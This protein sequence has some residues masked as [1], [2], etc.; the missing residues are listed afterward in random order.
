MKRIGSI[1]AIVMLG[2]AIVGFVTLYIL[3]DRHKA[4]ITVIGAEILEFE[5]SDSP[6]PGPDKGPWEV[7]LRRIDTKEIMNIKFNEQFRLSSGEGLPMFCK[8]LGVIYLDRTEIGEGSVYR[9][10]YTGVGEVKDL[11]H[12]ELI[13]SRKELVRKIASSDEMPDIS[14]YHFDYSFS[15][16]NYK[17]E[18]F[19]RFSTEGA[20]IKYTAYYDTTSGEDVRK[21]LQAR[22]IIEKHSNPVEIWGKTRITKVWMKTDDNWKLYDLGE[23]SRGS[24][25]VSE[26][27]GSV[28][29]ELCIREGDDWT[30]LHTS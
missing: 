7:T 9:L 6:Y 18:N 20:H 15:K 11:I 14:K 3:P 26:E 19:Y 12:I 29:F 27:D 10:K 30:L 24:V 1:I 21:A 23:N 22:Y 17:I 5:N 16:Q 28:K 13:Q 4:S 25:F 8:E 2:I